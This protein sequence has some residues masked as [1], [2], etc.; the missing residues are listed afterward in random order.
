MIFGFFS[1]NINSILQLVNAYETLNDPLKRTSYDLQ[2]KAARFSHPAGSGPNPFRASQSAT[3]APNASSTYYRASG[4]EQASPWKQTI[5]RLEQELQEVQR[6]RTILCS[7]RE[8]I[9]LDLTRTNN[10][11]KRLEVEATED[12]RQ[13][14]AANGW[15]AY[16]FDTR[17]AEEIKESISRRRSERITGEI[18]LRARQNS[19]TARL[20]SSDDAIL[21]NSATR[22]SLENQI[23][24]AK[25]NEMR[26]H[27]QREMQEQE[28]RIRR[29]QEE[30]QAE[31]A[32][33]YQQWADD[34]RRR[35]E[36]QAEEQAERMR[37][38][39]DEMAESRR[40]S[41]EHAERL[42]K[43]REEME[44]SRRRAELTERMRKRREEMEDARRLEEELEKKVQEHKRGE[45]KKQQAQWKADHPC[46]HKAWWHKVDGK[47]ECCKCHITTTRFA[48]RCPLCSNTACLSCRRQLKGQAK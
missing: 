27:K 13:Y 26:W 5:D 31:R 33:R 35:A 16:L 37:K 20:E 9:R 48:F 39:E 19:L 34:A 46:S 30:A 40:R 1:T 38:H 11:I 47:Y 32:R 25:T 21:K 17:R 36:K 14:N 41:D 28:E 42:R 2:Y 8:G 15:F 7:A 29:Q 4:S 18:V 24:D 6:T 12:D 10:S 22:F 43:H 45:R 3:T 23:R 44:E